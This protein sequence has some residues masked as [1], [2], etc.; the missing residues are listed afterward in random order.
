[1]LEKIIA[2]NRLD[3]T[4]VFTV[5]QFVSWGARIGDKEQALAAMAGCR[6]GRVLC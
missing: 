4:K 2:G 6:R 3:A 5:S 1:L